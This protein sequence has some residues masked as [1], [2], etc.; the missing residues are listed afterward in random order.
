MTPRE[1]ALVLRQI[2]AK[3]DASKRPQRAAV[4][5]DLKGLLKRIAQEEEMGAY[6]SVS[7]QQQGQ[8]EQQALPISG[9]GKKILEDAMAELQEA[10]KS[11]DQPGFKRALEKL[12]KAAGTRG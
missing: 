12:D 6:G 9:V 5:A 4:A 2:A 8:Q 10:V 3:I 7:Q 11:G 1:A